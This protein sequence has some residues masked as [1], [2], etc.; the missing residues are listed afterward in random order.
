[1]NCG[2]ASS[3]DSVIDYHNVAHAASV[4][5]FTF[6]LLQ[7]GGVAAAIKDCSS[8]ERE[9]QLKVLAFVLA[10]LVHD[11]EH[12]GL[13]NKFLVQSGHERAM[14]HGTHT[15]E[16]H[17]LAV[18]FELLALPELDFLDVLQD[19]EA[20]QCKSLVSSLVLAT[21]MAEGARIQKDLAELLDKAD[22][23]GQ[24]EIMP[25]AMQI[26]LKCADLGHLAL[27]W[28][29]HCS[30]VQRLETEFFAQ[31]DREKELGFEEVTFL[32]D[33]DKPGV[34]ETQVGFFDFVVLPLFSLLVRVFPDA[35]PMLEAVR[36]NDHC[37]RAI[38]DE[39]AKKA[40]RA[41]VG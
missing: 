25:L 8:S 37:W 16:W 27:P 3:D 7:Y 35:H 23:V 11:L 31:G 4:L 19:A 9:G 13:S 24:L 30:W 2:Y 18:A 29:E 40:R 12:P 15:N 21:D 33:R 10:A 17:H 5:V 14:S 34:S 20:E 36:C 28:H 32:M 22:L 41:T 1:V 6:R 39:K 38:A 26:A